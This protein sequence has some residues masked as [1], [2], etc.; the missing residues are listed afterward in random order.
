MPT[1]PVVFP[2]PT[3]KSMAWTAMTNAVAACHCKPASPLP[4]QPDFHL[5]ATNFF[6]WVTRRPWSELG[7]KGKNPLNTIEEALLLYCFGDANPVNRIS[8]LIAKIKPCAALFHGANNCVPTLGAEVVRRRG[9]GEGAPYWAF[10]D[11]L[12]PPQNP[13]CNAVVLCDCTLKKSVCGGSTEEVDVADL[14]E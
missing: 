13:P 4:P 7:T 5:V 2:L 3:M 1:I 10:S 11:N 14:E 8:K 12:A 6:P 9:A